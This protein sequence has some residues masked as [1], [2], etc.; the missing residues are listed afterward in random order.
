MIIKSFELNKIDLK[1]KKYF[2]L[3]GENQG[4]KNEIIKKKFSA[5]YSENIFHYEE[6]EVIKNEE[7]FFNNILTRSFFE[8]H[9]KILYLPLEIHSRE[10]HAKLYLA[11]QASQK[12]WVVVIG[13]EYDVNKLAQYMPAG[14]YF[15]NGFHNKAAKISK[16][17]YEVGYWMSKLRDCKILSSC[18]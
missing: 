14:V 15:G 16:N 12:G 1:G 10:F 3:Y 8:N 11:Y 6:N 18:W 17:L 4:H 5:E 13:P 9:D 2:L 7:G